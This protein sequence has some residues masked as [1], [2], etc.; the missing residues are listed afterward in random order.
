MKN[1]FKQ[2][3]FLFIFVLGKIFPRRGIPALF[4]H[5]MDESGSLLSISKK[6]FMGKMRYLK[7][8]G[9]ESMNTHEFLE[10]FENRK[11]KN[12]PAKKMLITF[13]DGYK[14]NIEAINILKE[15]NFSAVIFI[16]TAYIGGYNDFCEQNV[17]KLPILTMEEIRDL[18]KSGTE[19]GAHGHTHRNLTDLPIAEAARDINKSKQILGGELSSEINSFCY[20]RGRYTNSI[21]EMLKKLGFKVAFTTKT[22]VVLRNSSPYF[23]PR[24]PINDKVGNLQFKALL[25]PWYGFFKNLL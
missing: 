4:Y 1:Y 20:P 15:L 23:L 17:P 9:Y 5:S 7:K 24:V 10:Y 16:T 6:N 14:N 12:F 18:S 8:S 22:G 2:F 13:D 21:A 25:S 19:F 11:S 3:A